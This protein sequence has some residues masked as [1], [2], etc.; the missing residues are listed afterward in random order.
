MSDGSEPEEDPLRPARPDAELGRDASFLPRLPWRWVLLVV[1][2]VVALVAA[3][4]FSKRRR[5][6]GERTA[7]LAAL[8][9][10]AV[11]DLSE[12]YLAYRERLETMIVRAANGDEPEDWADPRL[13]IA[14]LRSGDGLYLR[15]TL[16][17]ATARERVAHG[18]LTMVPDS[19]TRCLGLQPTSVRGLYE[20]GDF[21]TPEWADAVRDETELTPL[22]TR[23]RELSEKLRIDGPA[24]AA[25]MEAD[26]FLLVIQRGENRAQ[27]PVDVY[28]WDLR[29]NRQLLRARIQGRGI[30]MPVR[31]EFSG[32][33]NPDA[34]ARPRAQT[35]AANDC[36]IGSQILALTGVEPVEIDSAPQIIERDRAQDPPAEGP[37][38]ED[39]PA[40]PNAPA[41]PPAEPAE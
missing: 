1:G 9:D 35:G 2:V 10:D 40:Q 31:M 18:A 7:V 37:P 27:H 22:R 17:D 23:A 38:A 33:N 13:N 21:L 14:G 20:K 25:M 24:L 4:Q 5:A 12:R 36:S 28:L 26:W 3:Y 39:P 16:H 41:E 15:I 30:L 8:R 34:P 29:Q 32:V 19:I 11:V 6:E